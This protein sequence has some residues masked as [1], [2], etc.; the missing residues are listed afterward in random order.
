[1]ETEKITRVILEA[2]TELNLQRPPEQQI[3]LAPDAVL[4]G[5]GG[6]LDSLG[7]VTL[8]LLVEQGAAERLGVQISLSDDRA[9]SQEENPFGSANA[10]AA[11]IA[12]LV[13]EKQGA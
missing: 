5:D 2:L 7:L 10:L 13:E 6:A 4:S 12:R 8:I 3:P 11:Y 1:M 9:L